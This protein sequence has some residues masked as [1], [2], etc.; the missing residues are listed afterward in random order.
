MYKH[1]HSAMAAKE[2]K[3]QEGEE[4]EEEVLDDN[5]LPDEQKE[6]ADESSNVITVLICDSG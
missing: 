6:K 4:E 5:F 2:G 1:A 3:L